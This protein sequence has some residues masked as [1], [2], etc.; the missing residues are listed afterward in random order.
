MWSSNGD[1]DAGKGAKTALSAPPP[2]LIYDSRTGSYRA[3]LSGEATGSGIGT[4]RTLPDVPEGDVVLMAPHGVVDAG[5]AGIRVSG[6]LTIAA[7]SIRNADNVQIS[8]TSVGMPAAHNDIGALTSA[9]N[10]AAASQQSSAPAQEN[11]QGPSIIIVE[12]LG[13]GG[14]DT[15]G[16]Q[17]SRSEQ[18]DERRSHSQDPQSRY[19]T[20]GAGDLTEQQIRQL[21]DE[22]RRRLGR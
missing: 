13:F 5:D 7:Q 2:R 22:R 11:N 14:A 1:I 4:L 20:V 16:R 3:E 10:T 19:Q 21:A 17:E 6:N 12:F 18:G 9:N 15:D 8:G